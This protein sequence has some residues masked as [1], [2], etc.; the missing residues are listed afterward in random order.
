M[1]AGHASENEFFNLNMTTKHKV[2]KQNQYKNKGQ[3]L[4]V[5]CF[6]L[7]VSFI[8]LTP[9]Y[10]LSNWMTGVSKASY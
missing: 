6:L 8:K 9:L 5:G 1:A 2:Q 4:T 3:K 7:I 10:V